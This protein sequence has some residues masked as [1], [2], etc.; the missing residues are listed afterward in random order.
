ME[1][2][3]PVQGTA[4]LTVAPRLAQPSRTWVVRI[5]VLIGVWALVWGVLAAFAIRHHGFD[6]RIY[7]E[8]IRWWWA[9]HDLYGYQED[10]SRNG[11]TYPPFAAVVL[12]PLA[13]LPFGVARLLMLGVNFGL[14]S[15]LIWWL[16]RPLAARWN[17]PAWYLIALG[18]PL[19]VALE[20]IRETLGF[21]QVNLVL[22]TLVGFDV[23]RLVRGHR[24]GVGVAIGLATA[25]KL[26]PAVFIVFL[27]ATRRWRAGLTA[28]AAAA[29]ATLFAAALDWSTS[30]EFWT[31]TL[32][33]TRRV[34]RLDSTPNQSVQGL[35]ARLA[36]TGHPS[37]LLWLIAVVALLAVA[38]HRAVQASRAADHLGALTIVGLLS[39]A[40]SPV[41][42][43]HHLI[44]IVPALA[45]LAAVGV[46]RP[47]A[48]W[49]L[50]AVGTYG[51]FASSVVWVWRRFAPHHW[52][53]GLLGMLTE[54]AYI[55][56]ILVLICVLPLRRDSDAL[57]LVPRPAAVGRR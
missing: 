47:S 1:I 20:P 32:W 34:G 50:A 49:L 25:V 55:L 36:D 21:G 29:A 30:W 4:P 48:P 7:H 31:A 42:W 56:A 15:L 6:L 13:V 19:A 39:C 45:V 12:S 5:G 27:F 17:W 53:H 23:V 3:P 22:A 24:R 28:T 33:R 43:T 54:N 9:G 18:L 46:R 16:F 52:D 2:S 38:L 11:F 57:L 51:L 8:S 26:T 44:W 35:L 37:R 14:L 41:G 40:A 10:G